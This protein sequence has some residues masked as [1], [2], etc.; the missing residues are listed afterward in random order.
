LHI[1]VKRGHKKVVEIILGFTKSTL[2]K[3]DINGQ[4]PLHCAAKA[5]YIDITCQLLAVSPPEVL[6]LED[7]VGNTPLE[8]VNLAETNE[9]LRNYNQNNG[10]EF[11]DLSPSE[12]K[13]ASNPLRLTLQKVE[14]ELKEIREGVESLFKDGAGKMAGDIKT[15]TLK[16]A[17]QMQKKV[18]VF[19]EK[20]RTEKDEE[21]LKKKLMGEQADPPAPVLQDYADHGE[22]L[23]LIRA[24]LTSCSVSLAPVSRHLIH[25]FDVQ[26]SVNA[27]LAKAGGKPDGEEN[28]SYNRYRDYRRN[29]DEGEL[30]EKREDED[31]KARRLSMVFR[32]LITGA[33]P[34]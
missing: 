24:T 10:F 8:I 9:R 6:H 26:R 7:S 5:A 20:L 15:A 34:V 29:R 1:A 30:E 17:E 33:D 23:S 16:W 18:E 13:I 31:M 22:T 27:T 14:K 4:T 2:L 3:R 11:K 32:Y 28:H 12:V 19:K 25:L 21:E